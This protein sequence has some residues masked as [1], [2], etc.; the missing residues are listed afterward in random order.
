MTQSALIIMLTVQISVT[1]ITA[2]FFYKMLT[3]KPKTPVNEDSYAD[4]DEQ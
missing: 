2:Y 4:N 3:T 1:L